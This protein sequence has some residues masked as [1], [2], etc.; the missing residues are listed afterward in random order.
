MEH[1]PPTDDLLRRLYS[2]AEPVESI[3]WDMPSFLAGYTVHDSNLADIRLSPRDGL[4]ILIDWDMVWNPRVPRQYHNLVI[5]VPQLYS[6][7][8]SEG[9]SRYYALADATSERVT[10]AE[11]TAMLESG[12]IDLRAFQGGTD[13][14]PPPFEDQALTRTTV[15]G[16][17][18]SRLTILH[19]GEVRFL[20]LDDDGTAGPIPRESR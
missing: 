18:W 13:E 5:G 12:P 16:M 1:W 2:T 15:T 9:S 7:S 10:E 8:W 14:I 4:L 20:C 11:R 19:G 17:N 3:A 6:V